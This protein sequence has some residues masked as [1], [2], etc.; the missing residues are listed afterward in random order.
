MK[1][2]IPKEPVDVAL[3]KFLMT[4]CALFSDA[5][6]SRFVMDTSAGTNHIDV[7][8]HSRNEAS[9]IAERE[10]VKNVLSWLN[11]N[12]LAMLGKMQIVLNFSGT[13]EQLSISLIRG[14]TSDEIL[15]SWTANQQPAQW[16]SSKT[17]NLLNEIPKHYKASPVDN[18]GPAPSKSKAD[19][20]N[21]AIRAVAY[22]FS[23]ANLKL[24]HV[25]GEKL[26]ELCDTVTTTAS[27][28][29]AESDEERRQLRLEHK[30]AMANLQ[31]ERSQFEAE[32]QEFNDQKSTLVR[33]KLSDMMN[34]LLKEQGRQFELSPKTYRKSYVIFAI[35][36]LLAAAQ[37]ALA[38]IF[39]VRALET[40]A[41][42]NAIPFSLSALGFISTMIFFIRWQHNWVARHADLETRNQVLQYDMMRASWFAEFLLEY[43]EE[44]AHELPDAVIQVMTKNLFEG[45]PVMGAAS[46]PAEDVAS[47]VNRLNRVRVGEKDVEIEAAPKP[48]RK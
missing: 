40:P 2:Y 33:R 29:R 45:Q 24:I 9:S 5:Y 30:S 31:T 6:P 8:F 7:S 19:E 25:V 32:K 10:D 21:E 38:A 14:A 22:Q 47:F 37:F 11:S 4:F 23:E 13:N 26:K 18:L 1:I 43:K 44:R 36:A 39:C 41:L 35:Y 15:L 17:T 20:S 12:S 46:H 48:K 3:P 42:Q 16:K 34:T 27:K 28:L